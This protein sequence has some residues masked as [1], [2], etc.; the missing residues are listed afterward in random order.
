VV[1]DTQL[2]RPPAREQTGVAGYIYGL[3]GMVS[4]AS[5]RADSWSPSSRPV[6]CRSRRIGA[7]ALPAGLQH[8]GQTFRV[9]F[10]GCEI[11][12]PSL[13]APGPA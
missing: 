4:S 9:G 5:G 12:W 8:K 13:S 3:I 11:F 7:S 6:V 2:Q 1:D 10:I